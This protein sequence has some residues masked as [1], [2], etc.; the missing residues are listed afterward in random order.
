MLP[1][2]VALTT[3]LTKQGTVSLPKKLFDAAALARTQC[4]SAAPGMYEELLRWIL[5]AD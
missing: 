3:F 1:E 2:R 4:E 5:S